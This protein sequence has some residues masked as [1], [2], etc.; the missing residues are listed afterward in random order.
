VSVEGRRGGRA[1]TSERALASDHFCGAGALQLLIVNFYME[2]QE[3]LHSYFVGNQKYRKLEW[4]HSI[5]PRSSTKNLLWFLCGR[6]L[7]FL[8]MNSLFPS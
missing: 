8:R 3:P 1:L 5:L 4:S 7:P 6:P 2:I